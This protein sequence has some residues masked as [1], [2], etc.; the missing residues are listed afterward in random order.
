MSKTP[1]KNILVLTAK[2]HFIAELVDGGMRAGIK[3]GRV[4]DFPDGSKDA[5][6]L[7]V[8]AS[9]PIK[10]IDARCAAL[11]AAARAEQGRLAR[12]RDGDKD[13]Q[14]E[15]CVCGQK[16]TVHPTELCGPCCFGEADTYGGNW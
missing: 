13:W 1:T 7:R 5:Q 10:S 16:P 6:L 14:T 4:V 2:G 12:L 9:S 3:Q 8:L 15:C 11:L